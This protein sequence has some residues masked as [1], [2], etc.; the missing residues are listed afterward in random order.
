MDRLK[1]TVT[2]PEL[3][4][5]LKVI[6]IFQ[7]FDRE[8]PAQLIA[9]FLYIAIHDGCHKQSIE[10]AL[11]MEPGSASRNTDWLSRYHRLENK[12]G[13]HLIIKYD[14]PVDRRR[15]MVKLTNKGK[16]LIQEI[17]EALYEGID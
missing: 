6:K 3:K 7:R 8:V 2:D 10:Q 9:T 13:L 4:G 17:K 15:K 12:P 5:L 1:R 11:K 16:A 14:D